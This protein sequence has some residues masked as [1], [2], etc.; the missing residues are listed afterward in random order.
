[1]IKIKKVGILIL[2][3]VLVQG[4]FSC[5]DDGGVQSDG[6]R[7]IGSVSDGNPVMGDVYAVDTQG[8]H[9]ATTSDADGD[10]SITLPASVVAVSISNGYFVMAMGRANGSGKLVKLATYVANP[11][12]ANINPLVNAAMSFVLND[13][14]QTVLDWQAITNGNTNF[15]SVVS[16]NFYTELSEAKSV[17]AAILTPVLPPGVSSADLLECNV[18][19]TVPK[20][21]KLLLVG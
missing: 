8:N 18:T 1:M 17:V 12:V 6:I 7:L 4:L 15:L 13:N 3:F 5:G 19:P 11:S 20:L 2:G 16:A 14:P 9:Y 21:M 10:Y